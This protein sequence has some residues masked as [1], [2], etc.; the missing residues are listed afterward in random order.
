MPKLI[1][2]YSIG[3]YTNAFGYKVDNGIA[4]LQTVSRQ[5]KSN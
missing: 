4:S 1:K 5:L 3:I 2:L